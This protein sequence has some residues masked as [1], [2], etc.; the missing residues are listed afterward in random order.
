MKAARFLM[1]VARRHPQFLS[2]AA[3]IAG[4]NVTAEIDYHRD[5]RSLPPKGVTFRI[6][7]SCDLRCRMCIYRNAVWI[8]EHW[9][10][11]CNQDAAP[12]QNAAR[13]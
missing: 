13:T 9:S 3:R 4:R 12:I 10:C 11:R 2:L 6:S 7:G 8:M 5:G 1:R